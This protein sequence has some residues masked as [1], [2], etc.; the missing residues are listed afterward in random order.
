LRFAA[1]GF[2]FAYQF[3]TLQQNLPS[4]VA[5]MHSEI[6]NF[7]FGGIGAIIYGFPLYMTARK[8]DTFEATAMFVYSVFVGIIFGGVLAPWIGYSAKWL[9]TPTAF[10]L[11]VGLGLLANPVTPLIIDRGKA[12]FNLAADMLSGRFFGRNS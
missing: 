7:L 8:E 6:I 3:V 2:L 11:A 12:F 4:G 5:S 1:A 10:P 9:V